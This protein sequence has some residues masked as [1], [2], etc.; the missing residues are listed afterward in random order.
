MVTKAVKIV[1][2][3]VKMVAGAMKAVTI[4]VKMVTRYNQSS[5]SLF[6]QHYGRK[7]EK[8]SYS[9]HGGQKENR[10]PS[11]LLTRVLEKI[12]T[13]KLLQLGVIAFTHM[14]NGVFAD[15]SADTST[16]ASPAIHAVA[17]SY[18][19]SGSAYD[20]GIHAF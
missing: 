14:S 15:P 7:S 10:V 16:V 20:P 3:A 8:D 18:M 6:K 1:T 11:K 17:A 5:R 2:G 9:S 4:G 19:Y 13:G 12:V